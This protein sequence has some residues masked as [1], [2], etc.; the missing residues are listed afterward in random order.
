MVRGALGKH[1]LEMVTLGFVVETLRNYSVVQVGLLGAA[2][3]FV[4]H[5]VSLLIHAEVEREVL[6]GIGVLGD[7]TLLPRVG[8]AL[9]GTVLALK[10]ST[11]CEL[12]VAEGYKCQ[13]YHILESSFVPSVCQRSNDKPFAPGS[14]SFGGD[15]DID[16]GSS[17]VGGGAG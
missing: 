17:Y 14:E 13:V 10:L 5:V 2:L 11:W 12:S 3:N 7:G 1:V 4:E 16:L 9:I 8:G 6:L 15:Y